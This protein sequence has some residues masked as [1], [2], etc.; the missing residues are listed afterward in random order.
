MTT[1]LLA[2]LCYPEA[3]ISSFNFQNCTALVGVGG[4]C[5]LQAREAACGAAADVQGQLHGAPLLVLLAADVGVLALDMLDKYCPVLK[6]WHANAG[7]SPWPCCTR[8][9][10]PSCATSS[11]TAPC[12]PSR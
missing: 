9:T 3:C 1:S 12:S 6:H 7:A 2:T 4:A 10:A 8:S 11:P 5:C